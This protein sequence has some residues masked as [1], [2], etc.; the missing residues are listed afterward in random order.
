MSNDYPELTLKL[1]RRELKKYLLELRFLSPDNPSEVDPAAGQELIIEIDPDEMRSLEADAAAYGRK[2]SECLF[3]PEKMRTALAQAQ[4]AADT[5]QLPLRVRLQAAP[6]ASEI[7]SLH[8]EALYDPQ[9]NA[10]LF[11]S[12]KLLFSRYLSSAALGTVKLHSKHALKALVAAA[13]PSDLDVYSLEPV[14]VPAELSHAKA[15]LAGIAVETLGGGSERVT[16]EAIMQRLRL[17]DFDILYIVAHGASRKDANYLWLENEQGETRRV[18][19]Q[20]LAA[21]LEKLVQPP[22]L[23]ALL[24]CESAGSAASPALSAIGPRLAEAGVPAVLAM[25]GKITLETG[26]KFMPVFFQTLAA[27]G[28]LDAAMAAGRNNARLQPDFWMPVLYTR[29]KT[30]AIYGEAGVEEEVT[31]E[32]GGLRRNLIWVGALIGLLVIGLGGFMIWRSM[33][34]QKVEIINT[35]TPSKMTKDFN[36]AVAEFP[37]V[38]AEGNAVDS[39]DGRN[40]AQFVTD[41]LSTAFN[42]TDL[43]PE[44][45]GYELT[46][47]ISGADAEARKKDAASRAEQINADVLIYGVVQQQGNQWAFSPEF[48][49]NYQGFQKNAPE[50]LGNNEL[51]QAL[52][53]KVPFKRSDAA[54]GGNPDLAARSKALGLLTIGLAYYSFDRYDNALTFF[55]QAIGVTDWLDSAGKE[56][57]Y[58]LRGNARNRL[59]SQRLD[60]SDI[61]LARQDY[62]KAWDITGQTYGRALLGLGS[63]AYV[64]ALK[65][66]KNLALETIDR[67]KLAEAEAIFKQAL[68]LPNQ[69]KEYHIEPKAYFNL[70]QV[71]QVLGGILNEPGRLDQAA[72]DYKHVTQDY[73]AGD[74]EIQEIA[75]LS[76]ARLGLLAVFQNDLEGAVNWYQKALDIASPYYQ[77]VYSGSLGRIYYEYGVEAIQAG[78]EAAAR[79]RLQ[80]AK[81]LLEDTLVRA[82]AQTRQDL[83][84][85]YQPVYDDLVKNYAKYL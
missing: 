68:A 20:E 62:Q 58:V 67:A 32:V 6:D 2:L 34:P 17:G 4:A 72:E 26:A 43:E 56:V 21:E 11:M 57:A 19:G 76:Y 16:L 83:I 33:T 78:N 69:P 55:D 80:R 22:V 15:A 66:P 75:S 54:T 46:G 52:P 39:T 13:N 60:F 35:P 79:A 1:T 61:D 27:E 47:K 28:I 71:D 51:G 44:I 85:E 36:V 9:G 37:V 59:D 5:S 70:G 50:I 10:P 14:D 64:Q 48:Y 73:E 49:V 84:D 7:H 31:R 30:C 38:D 24:A 40:L 25:Q 18:S 82:K 42:E 81:T 74:N 3:K 45:W 12:E 8:W 63:V 29:L 77:A 53:V 41:R 23:V 65:D